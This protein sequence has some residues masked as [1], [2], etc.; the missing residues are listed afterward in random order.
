[1]T[2]VFFCSAPKTADRSAIASG[3]RHRW[4]E[5]DDIKLIELTPRIL[6]CDDFS[7]QKQRRVAADMMAKNSVY[8]LADDDCLPL[9]DFESGIN[10]ILEHPQFAIVS[11][12]PSNC[13]IQRWTPEGY[14]V[15]EDLAVMEHHSVGGLRIIRRGAMREWPEQ[16]GPGY[17]REHCQALRDAGYRVGYSVFFRMEHLGEGKTTVWLE[18]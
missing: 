14:D 18:S 12:F 9:T 16:T 3:V 8:I 6:G 15:Y 11:A 2:E 17:D 7:F 10:A 5:L 4:K 1:M 13:T